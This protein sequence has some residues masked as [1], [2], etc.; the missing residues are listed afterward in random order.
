MALV[1]EK[2]AI[3]SLFFSS[4]NLR[5][6]VIWWG[7]R[8]CYTVLTM[9]STHIS[10]S[11]IKSSDFTIFA[12][13]SMTD[14]VSCVYIYI[15]SPLQAGYRTFRINTLTI[16]AFA[17]STTTSPISSALTFYL[18]YQDAQFVNEEAVPLSVCLCKFSNTMAFLQSL[19]TSA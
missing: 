1:Y 5:R 7:G 3:A 13:S 11:Y 18:Y 14:M 15:F 9:P 6:T 4:H 17:T 8:S 10:V 12:I 2:T 16:C 19:L